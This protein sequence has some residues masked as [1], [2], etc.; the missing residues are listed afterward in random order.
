MSSLSDPAGHTLKAYRYALRAKPAQERHLRRYLGACRWVWNAALA[1]QQARQERGEKYAGFAQMCK[2][3]T[4][5]RNAQETKWLADVSCDPLQQ[6]LKGLDKAFQRFFRNAKAGI[7]P[8]GYPRFKV[9]GQEGGLR[10]PNS[11]TGTARCSERT[12]PPT[13]ARL[14]APATKP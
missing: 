11:K 1:E 14:A 13:Q 8:P 3:L 9:R 10:F 7:G 2:W 6:T 5:W 12:G 4:S